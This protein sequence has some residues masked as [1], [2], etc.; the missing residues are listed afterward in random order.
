MSNVVFFWDEL[1]QNGAKGIIK[2]FSSN[3]DVKSFVRGMR[4]ISQKKPAP[5]KD[6][7]S[8][9]GAE[10]MLDFLVHCRAQRC[11]KGDQNYFSLL[12]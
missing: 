5:L 1:N 9:P 12:Q 11:L 4:N 2:I 7:P 3:H 10:F 6:H 8:M